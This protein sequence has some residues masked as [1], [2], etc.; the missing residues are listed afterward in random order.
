MQDMKGQVLWIGVR[1]ERRA[2]VVS[3][4]TV[5]ADTTSGLAGDHDTQPHR[6]V[7][8][9]SREGLDDA[10]RDLGRDSI[11]P[12]LARRNIMIGG[13]D[14]SLP[15]G[16]QVQIGE[17]ILEV[18]GECH[19]CKRMDENIGTGGRAALA[20]RAGLTTRIVR[21]GS[22]AVGESVRVRS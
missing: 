22:I 20:S 14:L 12:S 7:T 9:I 6:Q 19:G 21:G 11:H 15:T 3:V 5:I 16:T 2:P 13:L 8:L 18:T 10:A 1:P 17:V 4:D